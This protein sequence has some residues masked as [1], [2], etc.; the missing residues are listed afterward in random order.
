MSQHVGY[1]ANPR[2]RWTEALPWVAAGL[3]FFLLPEY[4]SLGARIL[5][6]ILFA[7]SLDL[8]IGYAG[9]ITLGHAAFFGLGAYVTGIMSAKLGFHDPIIQLLTSGVVAGGWLGLATGIILLVVGP[10][11]WKDI[12]GNAEPLFPYKYPALFSMTV[13]FVTMIVVSLLDRSPRAARERAAFRHQYIRSQ[14]GLGSEG[15]TPH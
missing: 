8:I 11:I 9:I 5:T 6:Y 13:T 12:L 14:T 1:N 10:T 15:A 7:L 3:A 4:L 2:L